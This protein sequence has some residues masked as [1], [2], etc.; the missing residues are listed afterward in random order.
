MFWLLD[1]RLSEKYVNLYPQLSVGQ[2]L[3]FL[4]TDFCLAYF[5]VKVLSVQMFRTAM[6]SQSL[7]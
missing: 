3:V 1:V 6:P 7:L 5:D 4:V 2:L